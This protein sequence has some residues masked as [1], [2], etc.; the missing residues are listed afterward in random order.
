MGRTACGVGGMKLDKGDYV[1][2]VSSSKDGKYVF[3]IG[4]KGFGKMSLAESYRKTKR[5]ARGVLALNSE[6]AGR[7]VY[8]ATVHGTEDLIIMTREGIAIRFSLRDVSIV[9]RNSKGVKLINIKGRNSQ[10]VGI[11]KIN[12]ESEDREDRE[13]TKEEYIEV[14]KELEIGIDEE[15]LEQSNSEADIDNDSNE[16][17]EE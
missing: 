17:D 13:L 6:K 10:I 5:N 3:S 12:D 11:A 9:G 4:S 14:T 7:L 8:A 2:S 16:S 15:E 1:V